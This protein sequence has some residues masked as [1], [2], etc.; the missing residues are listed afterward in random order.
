MQSEGKLIKMFGDYVLL[1]KDGWS[2]GSSN[3]T[4][5]RG[6]IKYKLSLRNC[7]LVE[8]RYDLDALAQN[9]IDKHNWSNNNNEAGDNYG[10]F[11]NGFSK[12]TEIYTDSKFIKEILHKFT[13]YLYQQEY[14]GFE[15]HIEPF[16]QSQQN[17]L[18]VTIA[19]KKIIGSVNGVKGSG[20]KITTYKT[21]PKFD[22]DGCLILKRKRN[23][24]R[25][26][27]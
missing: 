7:K 14:R 4:N 6:M 24:Y 25:T 20:D 26:N 2:I 27:I 16:L 3:H 8:C 10:S 12:A 22:E 5:V 1:D 15:D 21:V 9:W 13:E 19:T 17:G 23:E 18:D 11:K